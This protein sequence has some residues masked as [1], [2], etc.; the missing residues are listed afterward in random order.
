MAESHSNLWIDDFPNLLVK[1]LKWLSIY[2]LF[3]ASDT[4]FPTEL[5]SQPLSTLCREGNAQVCCCQWL[6]QPGTL[7]G[8]EVGKPLGSQPLILVKWLW[9][10]LCV[11]CH[12][13]TCLEGRGLLS[14]LKSQSVFK[15]KAEHLRICSW[16]SVLSSQGAGQ[17]SQLWPLALL[18]SSHVLREPLSPGFY[19]SP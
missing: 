14:F 19:L 18:S 9:A 10:C 17:T 4:I 11:C 1:A 16:E 7:L 6:G 15:E 3:L 13:H 2:W 12:V 5:A 8:Q